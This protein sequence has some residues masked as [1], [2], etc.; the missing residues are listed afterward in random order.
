MSNPRIRIEHGR[1][2]PYNDRQPADKYELAALG[3]LAD[4]C[5]RRGIKH[6]LD[7]TDDDIKEEIITT[8]AAII[9][10]AVNS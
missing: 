6:E 1:K 8:L 10:D 4:L 7:D 9:R 2:F 3:V 5:D